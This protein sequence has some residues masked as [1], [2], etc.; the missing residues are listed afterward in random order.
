MK[1]SRHTEVSELWSTMNK[2]PL[3]DNIIAVSEDGNYEYIVSPTEVW[4]EELIN[5]GYIKW[6]YVA[7]LVQAAYDM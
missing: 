4:W 6:C 1:K 3:F 7:D 2:F 5:D